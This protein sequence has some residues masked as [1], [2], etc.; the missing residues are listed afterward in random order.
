MNII[1]PTIYF[2]YFHENW[3]IQAVLDV[4]FDF[5]YVSSYALDEYTKNHKT[6]GIKTSLI[7][8]GYYNAF[9]ATARP[10]L[11]LQYG[12]AELGGQ[13]A[14]HYFNSIE[15]HDRFQEEVTNDFNL[16]D[17]SLRY[18]GWLGYKFLNNRYQAVLSAVQDRR[19]GVIDEIKSSSKETSYFGK[20]VILF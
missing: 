13:L 8:H 10:K 14:I 9:G 19:S 3:R 12:P 7:K 6:D 2:Q 11:V 5:A 17:K 1:G 18:E 4:S 16:S 20:I 15:G